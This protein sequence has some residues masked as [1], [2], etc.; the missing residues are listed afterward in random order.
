V[1]DYTGEF[2]LYQTWE[3]VQF[4]SNEIKEGMVLSKNPKP[5]DTGEPYLGSNE[6]ENN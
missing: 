5:L 3:A 4:W 1:T 2:D 6:V